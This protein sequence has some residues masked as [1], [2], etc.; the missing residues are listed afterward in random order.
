MKRVISILLS[1][2]LAFSMVA[3]GSINVP[4]VSSQT[5]KSVTEEKTL[6]IDGDNLGYPSVYTVSSKGRGYLLTSYIFDTLT[7]KDET[8]IIPLLAKKWTVS[9]NNKIWTFNLNETAKFTDGKEVTSEDVKFSFDYI[10]K[11]P[12]QWIS[13]SPVKEVRAIDKYTVEVELNDVHAPFI[14][15][16]AGNVPIMPKHIWE[17][18]TEPEKFN[19]QNAVIGSG[20]LKL[21]KYDKEAGSYVFNANKEYF[22]GA[23]AIDKLIISASNNPKASLESGELNGA[24]N[25]KYGEAK[26]LKEAGKFKVIEGPGFWVGR[27]YFNFEVKE[28]NIKEFRQALYYGINREEYVAKAFKGGAN[29]GNPGHIHPDSEWYSKDVLNYDFNPTKSKELLKGIGMKDSNSNGILEYKGKE[30]KYE[31][32]VADSDVSQAEMLKKYLSDIGIALV[33]KTLDSKSVDSMIKEGKFTLALGGHGSFGGDPVL[34][35]RFISNPSSGSTP[36]I[37]TQGGAKWINQ[38]FDKVFEEQLRELDKKKRYDEVAKLQQ[39]IA[40]ELPTLTLY[41]KKIVFAY[42][43]SVFDGWFFTKDGVAIA[44]PT[45]QNKLVFIKGSWKK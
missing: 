36:Q 21:E 17:N 37:T 43:A 32:I 9:S 20:P 34:L 33:V 41:Y 11:H 8:G 44:V 30:L 28:F 35:Q 38:E 15:D 4:Q 31:L 45:V 2:I 39:I 25:I 3:C 27:L 24:A 40:D 14:T 13:V 16:I 7:W 6:R 42:D 10:K 19:T 26:Q 23:P 5:K 12:Y 1:T 18:V 22:L 29:P